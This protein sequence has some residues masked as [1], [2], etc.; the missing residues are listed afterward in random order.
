MACQRGDSCFFLSARSFWKRGGE[1]P[2]HV[3]EVHRVCKVL[4]EPAEAAEEAI[5]AKLRQSG[6]LR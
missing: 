6:R 4:E 2:E 3:K 1:L 5:W